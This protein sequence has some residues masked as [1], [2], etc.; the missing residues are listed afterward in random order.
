MHPQLFSRLG[1]YALRTVAIV[2]SCDTRITGKDL[3]EQTGVP[4]AYQAKVLRKLV[5][6]QILDSKKGHHGGFALAPQPGSISLAEV[7]AAVGALPAEGE[8]VFDWGQCAS[9]SPCP[10][11]DY[12]KE[13]SDQT[14][15]WAKKTSLDVFND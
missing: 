1:R 7:L 6:A 15:G 10:L 13:L 14:L 11:H 4:S 12:W 5:E 2:A 8:C 3:A 9:N